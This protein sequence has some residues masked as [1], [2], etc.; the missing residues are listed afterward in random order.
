MNVTEE[1][2]RKAAATLTGELDQVPPAVSAISVGGVRSYARARR[3]EDVD[4]P[5]RRVMVHA[6]DVLRVDGPDVDVAVHCSAGT[7]VRALARDLGALLGTGGHLSALRRNASGPY[8]LPA[9]TLD[10]L[11]HD[12]VAAH[13]VPIADAARA[14]FPVVT[15]G[16]DDAR[17]AATGVRI[18]VPDVPDGVVAVCDD[19]GALI[20]LAEQRA[21]DGL[22]G[23]VAVF[24]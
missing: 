3:G 11:E 20:A 23:Y 16:A 7:Y 4:L 2:I 14:A 17:R 18:A 6:F 8:T 9:P 22:L 19:A 15:V 13:L 5:P 10:D 21:E 12:G 24:S 1:T